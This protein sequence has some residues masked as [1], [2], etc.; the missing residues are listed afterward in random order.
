MTGQNPR[1]QRDL[2]QDHWSRWTAIVARYAQRRLTRRGVDPRAYATLRNDLIAAC[3]SLAETDGERRSYYDGLEDTVRP[4]LSPRVLARTDREIL[5]ALLS[6]CRQVERELSGRSWRL[7]RPFPVGLAPMLAAGAAV[8]ALA[9]AL[10]AYGRPVLAAGRDLFDTA[11]LTIKYSG[12]FL[13]LSVAGVLL[14]VAAIYA[15][16]RTAQS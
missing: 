15:I 10:A 13:R 11:W 9:W 5:F 14:I 4:W 8:V 3:R 7:E 16:S 12:N 1:S 6:R 2:L